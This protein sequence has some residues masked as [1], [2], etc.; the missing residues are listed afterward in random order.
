MLEKYYDKT[1]YPLPLLEDLVNHEYK[2]IEERKFDEQMCW[3]RLSVFV[4]SI[5]VILTALFEGL[6]SKISID[7][8]QLR[9]AKQIIIE[10]NSDTIHMAPLD[11]L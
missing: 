4:A 11:T 8:G 5:A 1:I 7:E 2:S 6:D 9:R 3:T 10:Y